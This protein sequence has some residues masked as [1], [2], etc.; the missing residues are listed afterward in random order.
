MSDAAIQG[1]LLV[2]T[3]IAFVAFLVV[4]FWLATKE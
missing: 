4:L 2:V 3:N 1:I